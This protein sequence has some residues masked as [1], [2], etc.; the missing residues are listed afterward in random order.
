MMRHLR[1]L[2]SEFAPLSM[3]RQDM[4]AILQKHI[5]PSCTL[6]LS[7]RLIS[8]TSNDAGRVT[9]TFDDGTTAS[10]DILVGAD[11]LRSPTRRCMYEAAA[12]SAKDPELLRYQ[13]AVFSGETVYR[14]LVPTSKVLERYPDHPVVGRIL[15]VSLFIIGLA[16]M[17]IA[18][19]NLLALRKKQGSVTQKR[20]SGSY[21]DHRSSTLSSAY[22]SLYCEQW[23]YGELC[24]T[25]LLP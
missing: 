18:S 24:R 3:H 14:N 19:Q 8:H 21:T 15:T 13:D 20:H 1:L 12:Q 9:M 23:C 16:H 10:T 11:G 2:H 6:H 5:L 25:P 7:K 4:M 22:G 17:L